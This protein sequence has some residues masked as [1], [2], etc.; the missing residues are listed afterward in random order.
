MADRIVGPLTLVQF[1]YIL[2]GGVVIYFLFSTIGAVNG[3]L[4]LL[5]ALPI[6]IFVLALAF[7]KI[8]DQPF[9]KFVQAFII[10]LLRPKVRLWHKEG[11]ETSLKIVPDKK[12]ADDT[13][14]T[15]KKIQKSQLEQLI[16]VMDTG[17]HV[18]ARPPASVPKGAK[19]SPSLKHAE[20]PISN[21]PV[22]KGQHHGR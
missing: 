14:V 4:F 7:L 19:I 10:F 18:V 20:P 6:A 1:L 15:A 3:G 11:L 21:H 12:D 16:Q 9:P 13:T 5:I 17:G 22:K 2:V 8:Q